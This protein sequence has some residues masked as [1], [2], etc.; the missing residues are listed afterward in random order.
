MI[1]QTWSGC[2]LRAVR[3]QILLCLLEAGPDLQLPISRTELKPATHIASQILTW[4]AGPGLWPSVRLPLNKADSTL[5]SVQ[6]QKTFQ[7]KK[8][9]AMFRK[10]VSM[11]MQPGVH[12]HVILMGPV[13]WCTS[14]VGLW[15]GCS[16]VVLDVTLLHL[17]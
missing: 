5:N 17:V 8:W 1:Q 15:A 14:W 16:S 3:L 4:L 10:T 2:S 11:V 7:G 6:N 12:S 9:P 13:T